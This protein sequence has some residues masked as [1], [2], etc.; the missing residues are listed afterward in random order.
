MKSY[1]SMEQHKCLVCGK[2]FDT[3]SLL[4]DTRLRNKFERTTVTGWGLCPEHQKLFDDGYIALVGCD[5]AKSAK[6]PNGNVDPNEAYRTGA[7]AHLRF[8]TFEHM[9]NIPRGNHP[10]MFC[11]EEVIRFLEERQSQEKKVE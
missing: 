11:D 3:N 4:L 7:I 1:V 6:L 8:E 9:F 10:V 5:D 2:D